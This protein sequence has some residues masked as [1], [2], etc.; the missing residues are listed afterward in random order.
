MKKAR[1]V[2]IEEQELF[3]EGVHFI[4]SAEEDMDVIAEFAGS[5]DALEFLVRERPELIILGNCRGKSR[6]EEMVRRIWQN[7]L[8]VPV[9]L[10]ADDAGK[11][12]L[13][14]Y[15][16]TTRL[17]RDISLIGFIAAVRQVLGQ[18]CAGGTLPLRAA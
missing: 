8:N 15:G 9:V 14:G 18:T 4:L 6:T 17:P 16:V 1:V 2:I 7:G 11:S 3:R 12:P 13:Y 5:K 10:L